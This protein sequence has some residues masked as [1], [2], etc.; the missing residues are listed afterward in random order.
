MSEL[1][2]FTFSFND[3]PTELNRRKWDDRR[4]L[5]VVVQAVDYD[6]ANRIAW[7]IACRDLREP[8]ADIRRKERTP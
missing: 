2:T 8:Y 1:H 4:D 6:E 5:V 7:E 3:S